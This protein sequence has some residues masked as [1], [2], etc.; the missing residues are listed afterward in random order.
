MDTKTDV[1]VVGGGVVG[2]CTALY[3]G[4]AGYRVTVL[5]QGH[6]GSASD[7]NAGMI[8]PSHI[9]PLAAPGV[10]TK[11]LRWL[12]S[13]E[14]PF[15]IKPRVDPALMRW[16]WQFRAHCTEAHVERSVPVLRDLSLASV[17]LFEELAAME[18]MEAFGYANTGLLMLYH[19][20][21]GRQEN[22]RMAEQAE[23]AGLDVTR[24][25]REAALALDPELRVPFEGA[26]LYRQDGRVDP[27]GLLAA[28]AAYLTRHG[29]SIRS[30]VEVLGFERQDRTVTRVHTSAGRIA[31]DEVVLAAGAWTGRLAR[32]LGLRLPVQPAKGYSITLDLPEAAPRIPH[33]LT[34]EKLTVTPMP[35]RIRFA[36]TLALSGF[37]DTV[38]ARRTIPLRRLVGTYRPDRVGEE[39]AKPN[40]WYGYRPCSP[41]GLPLIGRARAFTN[42][43][44]A[45]GHGM[46]GVTL[47]PITGRLVAEVIQGISTTLDLAPFAADR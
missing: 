6:P 21:K 28:L 44:V 17:A 1:V 39:A 46:M 18:H 36:G 35:G 24:L 8:V 23:A 27:H 15:Y 13:P 29:V 9:V 26:V 10:L 22:L 32:T 38:D 25:D 16:L 42:L 45:T 3:L 2:L 41:D 11:G 37:D 5:D 19:T 31:A 14:S 34:E 20:E 33:I 30:G 4:R 47:A 7:G 40:V 43:T 12:L